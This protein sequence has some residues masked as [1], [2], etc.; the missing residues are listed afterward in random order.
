MKSVSFKNR[1]KLA[2][3]L[4]RIGLASVLLYASISAFKTPSD[5]I[6]FLP[7]IL[8]S[9]FPG[10]ILIGFFSVYEMLLAFW[11]LSGYYIKYAAILAAL[12]FS[13]IILTNLK[14]LPLT[15]RDITMVF[16]ALALI[17]IE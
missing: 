10:H 7:H 9:R 3:L 1:N 2:S 11:L 17:F 8:T 15:F 14:L 6:G 13:G 5:W 4:L 12:T 16:A